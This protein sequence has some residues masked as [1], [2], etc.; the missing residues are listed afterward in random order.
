M[1]STVVAF[2]PTQCMVC[3]EI[4]LLLGWHSR[5][6]VAAIKRS[7][8]KQKYSIESSH[9]RMPHLTL[10]SVNDWCVDFRH[11]LFDC[12]C[13]RSMHAIGL[14]KKKIFTNC[15]HTAYTDT[16]TLTEHICGRSTLSLNG[17]SCAT[18][19]VSQN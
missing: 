18:G 10:E 6:N 15:T 5:Q 16:L 2:A 8:T 11:I 19:N 13:T 9:N 12:F 7:K 1:W 17:H 14:P 3:N 4:E